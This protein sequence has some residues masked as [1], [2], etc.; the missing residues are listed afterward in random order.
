MVLDSKK[1]WMSLRERWGGLLVFL[2][3]NRVFRADLLPTLYLKGVNY[4]FFFH[5]TEWSS[6]R[7]VGFCII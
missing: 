4:R 2:K 5:M 7:G 1:R 6:K 3:C